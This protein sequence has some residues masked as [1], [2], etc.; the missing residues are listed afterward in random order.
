MA[1]MLSAPV[2]LWADCDELQGG[3]YGLIEDVERYQ[4]D[5]ISKYYVAKG[6]YGLPPEERAKLLAQL[7]LVAVDCADRYLPEKGPWFPSFVYTTT[8]NRIT[9]WLRKTHGDR[10]YAPRPAEESLDEAHEQIA[11]VS[12]RASGTGTDS[13]RVEVLEAFDTT[14]LTP[15]SLKTYEKVVRRMIELDLDKDQIADFYGWNRREI[16]ARL[17][18]LRRELEQRKDHAA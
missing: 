2:P 17:N 18:R 3:Q 13:L 15:A 7:F 12:T 14:G 9:D 10:R 4:N 1:R 5:V 16:N 11:G 8:W 6:G